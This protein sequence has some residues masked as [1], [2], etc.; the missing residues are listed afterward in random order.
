[1]SQREDKR[2]DIVAAGRFGR[3]SFAPM[4]DYQCTKSELLVVCML[5]IGMEISATVWYIS[6]F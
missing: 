6:D 4:K 2:M 1:M 5:V 3:T